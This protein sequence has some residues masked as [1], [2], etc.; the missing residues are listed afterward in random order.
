MYDWLLI[1]SLF[2]VMLLLSIW[3]LLEYV[4]RKSKKRIDGI[5][6]NL[7]IFG[8]VI[9]VSM[10]IFLDI[11]LRFLFVSMRLRIVSSGSWSS[12]VEFNGRG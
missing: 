7:R 6:L 1:L 9:F 11:C 2:V 8:F 3:L 10:R 5:F 12:D 4:V